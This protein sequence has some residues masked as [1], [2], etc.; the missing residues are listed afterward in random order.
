MGEK[1]DVLKTFTSGWHNITDR[2]FEKIEEHEECT[3]NSSSIISR[4]SES[5]GQ[6]YSRFECVQY[7]PSDNYII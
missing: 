3:K 4:N 6:P 1:D 2:M 7:F 5:H